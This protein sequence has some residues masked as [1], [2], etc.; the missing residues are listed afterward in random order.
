LVWCEVNRE[1]ES[2]HSYSYDGLR[3]TSCRVVVS[4][5]RGLT[6]VS[7]ITYLNIKT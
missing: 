3:S 1:S 2:E 5:S 4:I 7:I 6:I